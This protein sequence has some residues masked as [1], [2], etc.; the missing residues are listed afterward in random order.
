LLV[1]ANQIKNEN[2]KREE[3]ATKEGAEMRRFI[4]IVALGAALVV[5]GSALRSNIPASR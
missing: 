4:R 3:N 5:P 1:G 2:N